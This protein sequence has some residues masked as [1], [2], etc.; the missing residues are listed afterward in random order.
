MHVLGA[1]LQLRGCQPQ[2]AGAASP[3]WLLWNGEV[4]HGH[5][6]PSHASDTAVV[7]QHLAAAAD[8]DADSSGASGVG[9]AGAVDPAVVLP[10][11][12][13]QGPFAFVFWDGR[14]QQLWFG[15]DPV[16]RRSLLA[17]GPLLEGNPTET[18]APLM[19]SSC[20]VHVADTVAG[21]APQWHEVPPAGVF[22]LQF[23]PVAPAVEVPWRVLMA[24]LPPVLPS[25]A[26]V[27]ATPAPGPIWTPGNAALCAAE[28]L[29]RLSHAV[30]VRVA[31]VPGSAVAVLFSGGLD[32]TVVA[33]LAHHHLPLSQPIDL[34]N[35][36]FAAGRRSPDRLTAVASLRS[37]EA[38]CPGRRFRLVCVDR[39]AEDLIAAR[40]RV[41][42]VVYPQVSNMDL[43]IGSALWFAARGD[44]VVYAPPEAAA[45]AKASPPSVDVMKLLHDE[46]AEAV[47]FSATVA[48]PT[49]PESLRRVFAA[50]SAAD[51]P[52]SVAAVADTAAPPPATCTA[53]SCVR[54]T[55]GGCSFSLC[56]AC[57]KSRVWACIRSSPR[58]AD[59]TAVA[60]PPG[61]LCDTH[62][63]KLPPGVTV[64]SAAGA[65]AP[66]AAEP[67]TP[68]QATATTSAAA[69]PVPAG[70]LTGK[71][72]VTSPATVLLSGLGADEQLGGYGR[73]RSAFHS[74]GWAG[75][76]E[77]L[78][79][80][81]AR[82]WRRN[83]GRDD[84][85][86]SDHG[87]R[88]FA[89]CYFCCCH[90]MHLRAVVAFR[91]GS[92]SALFGR[93]SDG[94]FV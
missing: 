80:D 22:C 11:A 27:A 21:R 17:R 19:L 12:R 4:W 56:T 28:L 91:T 57:C 25:P 26:P 46:V 76:R 87:G 33:A 79:K 42:E 13:L 94:V 24:K 16:G 29:R 53:A 3:H 10:L 63:I 8:A 40:R 86:C 15:R 54:L 30:R 47:G 32:C 74:R 14:R 85:C 35:V 36:C 48:R 58:P 90:C 72:L 2:P 88:P 64:A 7:F 69:P 50:A 49:L 59:R 39:T 44:G 84:R 37:L 60:L 18:T 70:P 43:S 41:A 82:L 93:V 20:A 89:C 52:V 78:D 34:L 68:P 73:H 92:A 55:D 67:P 9:G 51:P 62:P 6:I 81:V 75:L 45:P 66:L 38:A 65:V 83:L 61:L 5:D 77:E 31:S 71:E 1:V 23:P